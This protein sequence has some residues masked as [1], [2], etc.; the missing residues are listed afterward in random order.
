[1]AAVFLAGLFFAALFFAA[2]FLAALFFAA[3]FFAGLFL[4]VFL[5]AVRFA[6]FSSADDLPVT[7][8]CRASSSWGNFSTSL[9]GSGT[10]SR[11]AIA[12][13]W[14]LPSLD[15]TVTLR[16]APWKTGPRG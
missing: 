1:M 11:Q 2:V 10:S 16:P 8:A 4:A 12:P 9:Q 3:L 13:T 6:G 5:A 14:I 15:I 7:S